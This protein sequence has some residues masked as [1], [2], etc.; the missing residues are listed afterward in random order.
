M[1]FFCPPLLR[2]LAFLP[3]LTFSHHALASDKLIDRGSLEFGGGARV[4]MLRVAVQ[5]DWE[6]RWF[7]SNGRHLG[8]YFDTSLAQ[9]RGTAY[10]NVAGQRQHITN[11][12][13]T[14][15]FRYRADKLKGWYLEGGIGINLLTEPYD[16]DETYLSTRY[17]FGDHIG[18]G[19]VFDNQW[20]VAAKIQ[21]FSNGGFKKPNSGVNFLLVKL[22]RPF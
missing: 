13:F 20:E 4:Q 5:T 21:H 8:G 16:N 14:P 3:A 2:L 10:L 22:A 19:Y 6:R 1:S 9:W 15:V 12:G 11:I 18:V 17:Q 7:A